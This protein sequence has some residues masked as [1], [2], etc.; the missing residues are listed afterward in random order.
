MAIKGTQIAFCAIA[1]SIGRAANC[2]LRHLRIFSTHNQQRSPPIAFI[3]CFRHIREH[4]NY[5]NP[6]LPSHILSPRFFCSLLLTR[7]T[8]N[9]RSER[10]MRRKTQR[11]NDFLC[12]ARESSER[13]GRVQRRRGRLPAAP[14]ESVGAATQQI[15]PVVFQTRAERW[16]TIAAS[17]WNAPPPSPPHPEH[18]PKICRKFFST[19]PPLIYL[20]KNA[21]FFLCARAII[22]Q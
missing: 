20:A 10:G 11:E 17:H 15:T 14:H 22:Q 12:V 6:W 8:N 1:R 3:C 7:K 13:A 21:A 16:R 2:I 18:A 5:P 4:P 19:A 9:R